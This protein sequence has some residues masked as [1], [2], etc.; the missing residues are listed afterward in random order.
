M[1]NIERIVIVGAGHA[2]GEVAAQ[3]RARNFTGELTLVGE[4]RWLPYQRP[5]LSKTFLA[6]ESDEEKLYLRPSTTYEEQR[7]T[8]TLSRAVRGID[9]AAH[10][11]SLD[12]GV[13][14]PYD[15]LVLATGG[16]A[17]LLRVPGHDLANV[18]PLRSIDDVH[19]LRAKLTRGTRLAVIGAGY[20]GLEVAAVADTLGVTVT[21]IEMASRAL[22]RVSA[23]ELSDFYVAEHESRGVKFAFDAQVVAF[24]GAGAVERVRLVDGSAIDADVVIVGAGLVPETSLAQDAGLT[25]DDGVVTDVHCRTNDPAI[26]A[27]GDCARR[28]CKYYDGRPVRG[29]SVHNATEGARIT[30]AVLTGGKVPPEELPW[31][32]SD[33]YDLKLLTG[34]LSQ[35]YDAVVMRGQ[36]A[37]RA[38]ALFYLRAGRVIAV[39]AVNLPE[40]YLAT[41]MAAQKGLSLAIAPEALRDTTRTMKEIVAR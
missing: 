30:A 27:I 22:S 25:L 20:I 18:F 12:G 19:A 10:T 31:N 40:A 29:E 6:A 7:I 28:P 15:A 2:G 33:Q 21:V 38:F 41:K 26:F 34:G 8:L 39:D 36:P 32:W 11:V 13:E 37:D 35:G 14:L 16:R 17:R 1:S 24:E 5:P 4:E 23:P 9:R 3:L